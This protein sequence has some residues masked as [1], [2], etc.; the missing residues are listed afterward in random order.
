M[1]DFRSDTVTKP[2]PEMLEAMM[3]AEVGDDVLGEDTTAN[4]LQEKVAALLEKEAALFVPSGT[5]ANAVAIRVWAEPG[6]EVI[7]HKLSHT[8]LYETASAA[9]LCGVQ[10]CLMDGAGGILDPKDVSDAVHDPEKDHFPRTRMIFIEN[11]HNIAG[12]SV[13]P[14]EVV[15]ELSEVA[16]EKGVVLHMDG[17]RLFNACAALG[18][19]PREYTRYVDSLSICFSKGLGAPV[20]SAIAGSRDFIKRAH[21]FRKMFG[22]GMRQI[23]YLAAAAL[24]AL[25]HNLQRLPEDHTNARLLAEAISELDCFDVDLDAVQTNMVFFDVVA[26]DLDA[27]SVIGMLLEEGVLVGSITRK[28]IRAVTHLDISRQDVLQAIEVFRK[29]FSKTAA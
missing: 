17:A 2:S 23:G 14:V 4:L 10:F 5:M 9:A 16:K 21:R 24:Y 15:K 26:D 29:L 6:D 11:T 7:I 18:V 28:R 22:G 27:A 8:Y 25:D 12:G 19:K 20:G 3:K 1:I 13:Y